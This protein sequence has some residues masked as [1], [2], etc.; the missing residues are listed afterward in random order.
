[1]VKSIVF[2]V[3]ILTKDLLIRNAP[4]DITCMNSVKMIK[5]SGGILLL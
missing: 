3:G 2:V 4:R 5:M 1:M